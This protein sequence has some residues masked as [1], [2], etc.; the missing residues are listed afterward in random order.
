M[1]ILIPSD[2]LQG[3]AKKVTDQLGNN[4]PDHPHA[5][6]VFERL[7]LL[8][9]V[10]AVASVSEQAIEDAVDNPTASNVLRARLT[11]EAYQEI[12][13]LYRYIA[14]LGLNPEQVIDLVVNSPTETHLSKQSLSPGLFESSQFPVN[15]TSNSE[16]GIGKPVQISQNMFIGLGQ[17]HHFPFDPSGHSSSYMQMSR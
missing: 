6:E 7:K 1:E 8:Y 12:L 2:H 11:A 17:S 9:T 5:Q 3:V 16:Q 4:P 10:E 13:R 15:P 14:F